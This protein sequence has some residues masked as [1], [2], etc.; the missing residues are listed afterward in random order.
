MLYFVESVSGKLNEN[1]RRMEFSCVTFSNP[2]LSY[3]D[4]EKNPKLF[5]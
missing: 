1:P 4:R 2:K 5:T 3:D